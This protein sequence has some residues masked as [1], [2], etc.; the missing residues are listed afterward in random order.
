M[1]ISEVFH[2]EDIHEHSEAALKMLYPFKIGE[3][4]DENEEETT[5][6]NNK[7]QGNYP[8]ITKDSIKYKNFQIDLRKG[9]IAQV[10]NLSKVDYEEF[11]EN[12]V[13]LPY[14]R[15]FDSSFMEFFTRNKWY[16][17]PCLWGT[18]ILYMLYSG[19][20]YDYNEPSYFK[21]YLW[22]KGDHFSYLNVFFGLFMGL[23]AWTKIEYLLHRF[24]FHCDWWLPDNKILLHFHFL[25]HGIH[26]AIP[27]DP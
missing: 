17:I 9:L 13:Y 12:P 22:I 14:C 27:M 26:H 16:Y 6:I 2:D 24:L 7:S 21:D 19:V 23:L 10:Y 4:V 1:D 20:T 3:I 15:L 5:Q 25:L 11:I 8:F 18:V